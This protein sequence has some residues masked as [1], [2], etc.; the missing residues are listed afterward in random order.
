MSAVQ[1]Q[2]VPGATGAATTIAVSRGGPGARVGLGVAAL[3]VVLLAALPYLMPP[4]TT[5]ALVKLFYLITLAS[6]WNMLAGYAGMVSIGQQAYIGLGAYGVFVV[7][8]TG[9][10]VWSGTV[11]VTLA[12][13]LI[14]WPVSYLA[15]RLRGGYFAV[16]TWVLAEVARLIVIRFDSLGAGQGRSLDSITE[17]PLLRRAYT[18]WLA[19]AVMV[20]AV[21]TVY[22]VLRSRFG[23]DMQA[24]RDEEVAAQSLGVQVTRAKRLV[25]IL[26]AAGCA[27][28][29]AVICISSLGVADPDAIFGVQYSAFMI[30]MVVI[31][32]IG[33][34]EGPVVGALLYFI[35]DEYLS[36]SGVWYLVVL[37]V[38]AIVIALYLPRG[39]WGT[40]AHR[41]GFAVFAIRHRVTARS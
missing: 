5:S 17:D 16:G 23:L 10:N 33:T 35:L 30:F 8:D 41:T 2:D 12:I 25:F 24:T 28:A 38:A 3:L 29:G 4:G 13:A 1:Q 14:A 7:N 40:F 39:L 21:L 26:T 20:V 19:L 9:M 34:V 31:G 18:Y 27:A 37:G 15:F 6:M 32:G 36:Q 11:V 22:G